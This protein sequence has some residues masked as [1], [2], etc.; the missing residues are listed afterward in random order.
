MVLRS[1]AKRSFLTVAVTFSTARWPPSAALLSTLVDPM[2]GLADTDNGALDR[3]GFGDHSIKSPS[4][5]HAIDHNHLA[6]LGFDW[7]CIAQGECQRA[8]DR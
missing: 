4:T 2:E 8:T 1:T 5:C 3:A 7:H 6:W